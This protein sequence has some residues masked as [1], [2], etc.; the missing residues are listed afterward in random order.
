MCWADGTVVVFDCDSCQGTG[1]K[2]GSKKR[3]PAYFDEG[4]ATM[5]EPPID[6][7]GFAKME[8]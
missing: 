6:W 4:A 7:Y 8:R 5:S 1:D 3:T 2:V